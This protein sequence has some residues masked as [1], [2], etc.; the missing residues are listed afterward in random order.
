[1]LDPISLSIVG[2]VA[3]IVAVSVIND[4]ERKLK[5][6]LRKAPLRS[7][8]HL[9]VRQWARFIGKV[10]PIA[11]P[12][13][14][15]LS[16][17]ACAFWRVVVQEKRGKSYRTLLSREQGQDFS[18]SDDTG[19]LLVRVEGAQLAVERDGNFSSGVWNEPT[20]ALMRFLTDQGEKATGWVFNRTLRFSEAV[21]EEAELVAVTGIAHAEPDPN[22]HGSS[23]Y[24]ETP[25]RMVLQG[26][27]DAPL[28][29]TDDPALAK[30][31]GKR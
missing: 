24:R 16:N 10:E 5:R 30:V 4:T 27:K 11:E 21:I 18:I 1:M 19:K 20:E 12:L 17:R 9:P 2:V 7:I 31:N 29:I 26:K 14:A 28:I 23:G 8:R 22:P 6:R 13:S 15:P 25:M 3:L